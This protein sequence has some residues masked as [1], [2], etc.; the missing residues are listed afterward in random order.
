MLITEHCSHGHLSLSAVWD[1]SYTQT[2]S[3]AFVYATSTFHLTPVE[4]HWNFNTLLSANR[5]GPSSRQQVLC[6]FVNHS[7]TYS[8]YSLFMK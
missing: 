1:T 8:G 5:I 6:I 4:N 2:A 3:Q 7:L